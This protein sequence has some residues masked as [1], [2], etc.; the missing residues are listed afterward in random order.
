MLVLCLLP[1]ILK[2]T[3]NN[4]LHICTKF[5]LKDHVRIQDSH[6]KC[7]IVSLEQRCCMQFLLSMYVILYLIF[8]I[9]YSYYLCH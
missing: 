6:T 1:V 3:I 5:K 9:I 8:D 2:K 4:T 7:K